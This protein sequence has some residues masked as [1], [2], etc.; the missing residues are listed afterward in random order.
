M[1]VYRQGLVLL[2]V[3]SLNCILLIFSN[4]SFAQIKVNYDS[5]KDNSIGI[6]SL[7]FN[8]WSNKKEGVY[9]FCPIG[10]DYIDSAYIK[11]SKVY[12]KDVRITSF[13]GVISFVFYKENNNNSKNPYLSDRYKTNDSIINQLQCFV[14][15]NS[16]KNIKRAKKIIGEKFNYK[17]DKHNS[18]LYRIDITDFACPKDLPSKTVFYL[19][20]LNEIL[21]PKYTLEEKVEFLEQRVKKLELDY[22]ILS[23]KF[24]TYQNQGEKVSKEKIE[25][26]EDK[27]GEK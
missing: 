13:T 15:L 11:Q 20:V 9:F 6:T 1:N 18:N 26:S 24:E 19:D 2:H 23:N 27:K 12:E 5:I 8:Q 3:I 7:K 10:E 14:L 16:E 22:Y 17:V 25:S 21:V 4:S